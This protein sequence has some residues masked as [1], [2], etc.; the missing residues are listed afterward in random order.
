MRQYQFIR[1]YSQQRAMTMIEILIVIAILGIVIALALPS[2]SGFIQV[3]R[4]RSTT[5]EWI[6]S[7][8]YAK[9]EAI[10]R[11]YPVSICPIGTPGTTS[12]GAA[13]EDWR[14]GWLIFAN[15]N[16]AIA[17]P[18]S[19][20]GLPGAS[21]ELLRV[22]DDVTGLTFSSNPGDTAINFI[23]FQS[24][25][26]PDPGAGTLILTPTGCVSDNQRKIEVSATGRVEVTAQNCD[27]STS[28]G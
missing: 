15:E 28:S 23:T 21:D 14:N 6:S 8:D 12:C 24:S 20:V 11:G 22:V 27:G 4:V 3:N 2:M 17:L 25:G 19:T 16:N 9:T 1:Q 10:T 13:V 26:F 7:L 18:G 5:S